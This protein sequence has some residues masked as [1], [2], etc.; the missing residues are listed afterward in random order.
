MNARR[1]SDILN[2]RPM[3]P[4]GVTVR[5]LD[6]DTDNRSF[7]VKDNKPEEPVAECPLPGKPVTRIPVNALQIPSSASARLQKK[8]PRNSGMR[9][10]QLCASHH[11]RIAAVAAIAEEAARAKRDA[12]L[13]RYKVPTKRKR[14]G[15]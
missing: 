2:L 6:N 11:K 10:L 1:F 13:A 14:N 4:E 15:R 7:W 9:T 5:V 8:R 3:G 12:W